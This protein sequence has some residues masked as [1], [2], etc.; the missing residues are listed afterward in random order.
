MMD[1][2]EELVLFDKNKACFDIDRTEHLIDGYVNYRRK[3]FM[4][5][6]YIIDEQLK[7]MEDYRN[8]LLINEYPKAKVYFEN[9]VTLSSNEVVN[10][11]HLIDTTGAVL[12]YAKF[13]KIEKLWD[14]NK[15]YTK[16]DFMTRFEEEACT[17]WNKVTREGV[18]F[19]GFYKTHDHDEAWR[20]TYEDNVE[21][22][23]EL[24][25]PKD[26]IFAAMKYGCRHFIGGENVR[27]CNNFCVWIKRTHK[28]C[29][30]K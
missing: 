3:Y 1:L 27:F 11:Y 18:H 17:E 12:P 22:M 16:E 21:A 10:G 23:W 4:G 6:G 24:P 7:S 14:E 5:I 2:F 28:S 13:L 19:E 30:K 29:E 25:Y 15:Q 26:V 8:Q 20:L 9:P